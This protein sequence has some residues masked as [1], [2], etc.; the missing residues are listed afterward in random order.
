MPFVEVAES[1]CGGAVVEVAVRRMPW[2]MSS[3]GSRCQGSRSGA[4]GARRRRVSHERSTVGLVVR[5]EE[6]VVDDA[7]R[8]AC[9]ARG[10]VVDEGTWQCCQHRACVD[11]DLHELYAMSKKSKRPAQKDSTTF[12]A[13]IGTGPMSPAVV[14]V[15][16]AAGVD[17]GDA[18][19]GLV[20]D[21]DK[22]DG[23]A[24]A[25]TT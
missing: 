21:E 8:Q 25:A 9:Q 17:D 23:R 16:E 18:G 5:R 6:D 11:W 15:D 3:R 20:L 19:D 13:P 24:A 7:S 1:V 2:S 10:H 22:G 14:G 12:A 4:T